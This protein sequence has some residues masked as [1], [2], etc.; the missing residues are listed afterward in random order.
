M[1]DDRCI[2]TRDGKFVPLKV[3]C[4]DEVLA[5]GSATWARKPIKY[6]SHRVVRTSEWVFSSW[7]NTRGCAR[8]AMSL[9]TALKS[10]IAIPVMI[11]L[12]R[13]STPITLP[14]CSDNRDEDNES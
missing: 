7:D 9:M 1:Y 3:Q 5:A 4:T 12:V 13:T 14:A 2:D 6:V 11:V 10:I 8:F